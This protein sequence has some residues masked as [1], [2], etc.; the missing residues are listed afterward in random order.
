VCR[1]NFPLPQLWLYE[2]RET[3]RPQVLVQ[4]VR[5]I[6]GHQHG[7]THGEAACDDGMRFDAPIAAFRLASIGRHPVRP[8]L[9]N[10]KV[11]G[12]ALVSALKIEQPYQRLRA[13]RPEVAEATHLPALPP[14]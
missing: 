3:A 9:A 7:L 1:P 13:V 14:P 11:P 4:I 10:A 2:D 6:R 5:V 8:L 12:A